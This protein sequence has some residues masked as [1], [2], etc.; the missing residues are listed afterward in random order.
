[1]NLRGHITGASE[2][3]GVGREK[4]ERG[5]GGGRSELSLFG[6][7]SLEKSPVEGKERGKRGWGVGAVVVGRGK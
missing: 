1:M 3:V 5:R 4:N 2:V 7:S 6:L